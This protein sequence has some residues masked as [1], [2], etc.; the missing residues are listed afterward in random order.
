VAAFSEI[1]AYEQMLIDRLISG[2]QLVNRV[3]IYGITNR[4]DWSKRVPT[5]S[6]RKEGTTPE[7]LAKALADENIFAWNGNFYALNLSE[8][9]GVEASG[10][11]LRIG[12]V[13]YNTLEE[14]DRCMRVLESV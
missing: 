14:I 9:L 10:G 6:I 11:L 4:F 3:R 7:Q 8:Q 1:Q 13:H 12:L 5:V 2:L